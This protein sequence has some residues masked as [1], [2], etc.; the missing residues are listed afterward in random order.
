M[1]FLDTERQRAAWLILALGLALLWVLW[2]FATGL[3]VVS[4]GFFSA[5]SAFIAIPSGVQVVAWITTLWTGRPRFDTPLLFTV[6]FGL[7]FVIGGVTGVM[8]AVIPFDQ[9]VTE[10]S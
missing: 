6:G 4:L 1:P 7:L 5:A 8:F 9:S 10:T 3:P 2:P